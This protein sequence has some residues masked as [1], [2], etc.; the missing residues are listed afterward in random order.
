[1]EQKH[2]EQQKEQTSE[3]QSHKLSLSTVSQGEDPLNQTS[4]KQAASQSSSPTKDNNNNNASTT[5]EEI[6]PVKPKSDNEL[7]EQIM[8]ALPTNQPQRKILAIQ[9]FLEVLLD[10]KP[11]FVSQLITL[12]SNSPTDIEEISASLLNVFVFI[13]QTIHLIHKAIKIEISRTTDPH[14]LFRGTSVASKLLSNF[15]KRV[16]DEY[17]VSTLQSDVLK[18]VGTNHSFEVDPHR[19]QVDEDVTANAQL[20]IKSTQSFLNSIINSVDKCPADIRTICYHLKTEVGTKFEN[21]GKTA[22]AGYIFLRFFNP[23]ITTPDKIVQNVS[24]ISRRN[25]ILVGKILQ[26]SANGVEFG[27]KEGFMKV[28]NTFIQENKKNVDDFLEAISTPVQAAAADSNDNNKLKVNAVS[29]EQLIDSLNS[30]YAYVMLNKDRL[31]T[32]LAKTEEGQQKIAQLN[33]IFS[34]LE[35]GFI[36]KTLPPVVDKDVVSQPTTNALYEE[37]LLK[38]KQTDFKD[39]ESLGIIF[40][41]GLDKQGRPIVVANAEKMGPHVDMQKLFLYIISIMDPLVEQDYILIYVHTSLDADHRPSFQWLK[42]A[43]SI[44]NRKYKKNVKELYI[45]RPSFWLK[46]SFGLFRPFLSE[47]FWKKLRYLNDLKELHQTFPNQIPEGM[48]LDL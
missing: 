37:Y 23:T 6:A 25:L 42:T 27:D 11:D 39:M 34:H 2:D 7:V 17:L 16:G 9:K 41:A 24:P 36:Q 35:A 30:I 40:M 43:Y 5:N 18:I 28:A 26:N 19:C 22:V 10:D 33:D 46:L 8:L 1:M 21:A 32:E 44:F 48:G 47:K 29:N 3:P 12:T 45:V 20:L 14:V 13:H 38:A 4:S 31:F 15:S